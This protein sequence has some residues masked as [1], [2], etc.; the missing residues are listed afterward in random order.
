MATMFGI[1]G[2]KSKIDDWRGFRKTPRPTNVSSNDIGQDIGKV[3]DRDDTGYDLSILLENLVIPKLIAD[4]GKND[5]WLHLPSLS[6]VGDTV[7]KRAITEND[8]E[9]FTRL[10]ISGEAHALLDFVD[11]RLET[12]SS[13]ETIYVDLLAPAARRLGEFWEEDGE[14]F[15]GVTMGLWR[16]QEILRELTVRIP[17]VSRPGYGKR[18]A[19][20]SPMP[21]SQ[22][23]FGTLMVAECF[24]RAGWDVDVLIQPTQSELTGKF[25]NR[26]YDLIGLTVSIDCT[27]GTLSGL[28]NTFRSVSSNPHIKVLIGGPV[29]NEQPDL[30]EQCGADATAIDAVSAV[31]LGDRLVPINFECFENLI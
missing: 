16:I 23:S 27:K 2:L 5:N 13:V 21:G 22:H 3:P 18:S 7:R 15:V 4:Q 17:P 1:S 25:A 29:I 26:H 24:Q 8:V 20:F 31:A 30:V 28:V 9:A 14:D 10:S 11:Q 6:P 19:L 12:G